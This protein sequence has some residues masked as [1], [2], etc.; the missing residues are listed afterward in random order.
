MTD[1]AASRWE[2]RIGSPDINTIEPLADTLGVSVLELMWCEQLDGT[3]ID[4]ET[5]S[6]A[7]GEFSQLVERQGQ[8]EDKRSVALYSV[9]FCILSAVLRAIRHNVSDPARLL[10]WLLI[11]ALA[12]PGLVKIRQLY[13]GREWHGTWNRMLLHSMVLAVAIVGGVVIITVLIA[14]NR[15]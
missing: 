8:T 4:Q 15:P 12:I 5:T 2:R 6:A 1:K 3:S 9:L 7:L 11:A 10:I 13:Q 14:I